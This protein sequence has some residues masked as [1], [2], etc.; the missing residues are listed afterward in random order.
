MAGKVVY[1]ENY[2]VRIT[3]DDFQRNRNILDLLN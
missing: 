3:K 1:W 2:R